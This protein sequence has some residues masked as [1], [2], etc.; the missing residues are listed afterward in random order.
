MGGGEE[1]LGEL[2]QFLQPD[3]RADIKPVALQHILGLTGSVGGLKTISECPQ[4]LSSVV[5][6]FDDKHAAIYTDAA[7]IL[8]N[9]SSDP[10]HA[11]SLVESS[12]M[13]DLV[14]KL[15]S[16][17]EDEE[18]KLADSAAIILSNFTR[19][20]VSCNQVLGHLRA[21]SITI[22]RIV[23]I[24]CQETYNKHGF[25][26][27]FLAAF[28]SNLSQLKEVRNQIL[29]REQCILQ[30]LLP[31]T[32]YEGSN[33]KRGG[34]VGILRNCCFEQEHHEWLLHE[35]IDILP[36]LLLPLA[37]PTPEHLTDQEIESLPMELQYLD[38]DKKVESDPGIRR[39]LLEAILQL[40]AKKNCR[41]IVRDKN[42]YLIL[43]ELHQ[44]DKDR[45]VCLAAENIIDILIKKEEEINLENYKDVEVPEEM[46]ENFKKMDQEYLAD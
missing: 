33:A 6:L 37:G 14:K 28:L 18:S 5:Q 44:S 1:D 7:K 12:L 9:F 17:I 26:M 8:I 20:L 19:D 30:R 2:V 15:Y 21:N 34:V 38:D 45:E 29:D 24:M 13:S 39:M 42:S 11:K 10:V 31:F 16:K 41:E 22:E 35:D 27:N 23:F 32:E 25:K 3:Q 4:I 46:I 36:R 40:C 43:K